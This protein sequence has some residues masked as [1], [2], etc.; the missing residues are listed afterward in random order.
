MKK[1]IFLLIVILLVVSLVLTG[2]DMKLSI[3][4]NNVGILKVTIPNDELG[5]KEVSQSDINDY[6]QSVFSASD[7]VTTEIT[8]YRQNRSG[9]HL[10]IKI[11]PVHRLYDTY[12]NGFAIGGAYRVFKEFALNHFGRANWRT[13]KNEIADALDDQLMFAVDSKGQELDQ[14]DTARI[15]DST[16]LRLNKAVYIKGGFYNMTVTLPGRSI[17]TYSTT[18]DVVQL[19]GRSVVLGSGDVLMIYKGNFW[20]ILALIVVG[21]LA[22]IILVAVSKSKKKNQVSESSPQKSV[23]TIFCDKCKTPASKTDKFCRKCGAPIKMEE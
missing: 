13:G 20:G 4:D 21:V 18:K 12:D 2:C 1:R 17:I 15:M 19:S 3:R 22:I 16:S 7:A 8:S 9:H 5:D 10:R 11:K 23:S 14:Y 6:V